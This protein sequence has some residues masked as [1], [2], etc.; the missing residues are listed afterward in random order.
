VYLFFLLGTLEILL[1]IRFAFIT[2]DSKIIMQ[3]F[4][5]FNLK[6]VLHAPYIPFATLLHRYN[7][8][9]LL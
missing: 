5:F 7:F 4:L 3:S 8:N 2:L 9:A 1:G 6:P